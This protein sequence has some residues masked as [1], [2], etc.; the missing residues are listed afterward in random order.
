MHTFGLR[1]LSSRP[2][3]S[4][5]VGLGEL[6]SLLLLWDRARERTITVEWVTL[7]SSSETF[8][9]LNNEWRLSLSSSSTNGSTGEFDPCGCGVSS[10]ESHGKSWGDEAV[11]LSTCLSVTSVV[12]SGAYG[13]TLRSHLE[14]RSPG[15]T[16]TLEDDRVREPAIKY[17]ES[18]DHDSEL[19]SD[20]A[21]QSACS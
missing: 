21:V 16:V 7:G 12:C 3:S 19:A 2:P 15:G 18:S 8:V 5:M 17:P 9:P 11:R 4:R 6:G 10:W 1:G 13:D 14:M 20:T